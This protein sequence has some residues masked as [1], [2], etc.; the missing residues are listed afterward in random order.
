MK[1]FREGVIHVSPQKYPSGSLLLSML[2]IIK[3][4]I[5]H[6]SLHGILTVLQAGRFVTGGSGLTLVRFI[7]G[8]NLGTAVFASFSFV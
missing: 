7:S 5:I 1:L 8:A 2:K 6:E 4:F 3:N